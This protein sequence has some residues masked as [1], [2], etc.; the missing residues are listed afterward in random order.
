MN[1]VSLGRLVR[2]EREARMNELLRIDRDTET[3]SRLR[4]GADETS[5]LPAL[6][7]IES[8]DVIISLGWKIFLPGF[9]R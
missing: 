4:R 3:T 8:E 7:W 1:S 5:A 9:L 2:T 6:T